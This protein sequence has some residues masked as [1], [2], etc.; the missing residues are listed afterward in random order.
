LIDQALF[1]SPRLSTSFSWVP[2]ESYLPYFVP[3]ACRRDRGGSESGYSAFVRTSYSW[4]RK[5]IIIDT[6]LGS[7][8]DGCW[9]LAD[10]D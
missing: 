2:F 8:L 9:L 6:T 1:R 10:R 3:H 5:E 4:D 7:L